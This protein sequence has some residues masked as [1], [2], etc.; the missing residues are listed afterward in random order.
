MKKI[1][2]PL[3]LLTLTGCG[4]TFLSECTEGTDCFFE[5]KIRIEHPD[6]SEEKIYDAARMPVATFNRIYNHDYTLELLDQSG[7]IEITDF[8]GDID[9]V[10]IAD[11]AQWIEND[12]L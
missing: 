7:N 5:N 12:N 2:I 4:T 8:N 6:W 1:F 10:N 3:I 11:L 9:T